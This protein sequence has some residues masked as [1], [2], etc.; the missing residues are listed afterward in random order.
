MQMINILLKYIFWYEFLNDLDGQSDFDKNFVKK[1]TGQKEPF[2]YQ[3]C[4][5]NYS[6]FDMVIEQTT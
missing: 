5:R 3:V 6:N 4:S 2:I 1:K